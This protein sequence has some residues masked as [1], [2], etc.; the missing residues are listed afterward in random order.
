PGAALGGPDEKA[1]I[2]ATEI[3]GT[4]GATD[5]IAPRLGSGSAAERAAVVR[6]LGERVPVAA[7][8]RLARGA[9]EP[10]AW[11]VVAA[12]A[13]R[14]GRAEAVAAGAARPRAPRG[15]APRHPLPHPP[16]PPPP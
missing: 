13:G 5:A 1:R 3:L 16:A 7:A 14:G 6:A 8:L 10:D 11:L 12:A 4:V 15:P 9:A 2:A